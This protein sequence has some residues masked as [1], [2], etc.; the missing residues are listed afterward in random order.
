M[1]YYVR[2][3]TPSEKIVPASEISIQGKYIKLASGMDSSWDRIEIFE[4]EDNLISVLER[5]TTY[6]GSPG[7]AEFIKIRASVQGSYPVSAREWLERYLGKVKTIY[8]FQLLTDNITRNSWSTLGRIQNYL[9]DS[10][11]GI[12]QSDNEGFYNENGDYIL[13]QMYEGAAGMIPAATLDEEGNWVS[14]Q[15]RLKDEKAV[16]K[17]NEGIIPPKSFLSRLLGG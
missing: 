13:W 8:R 7:E 12:I 4:P 6:P 2:L 1:A 10:L 17:F 16:E 11:S 5:I 3:L 14:Y 9:K 15:L